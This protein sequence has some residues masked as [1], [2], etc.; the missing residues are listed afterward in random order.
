[1]SKYVIEIYGLNASTGAFSRLDSITTFKNL[2][3]FNKLNGVG[4]CRFELAVQDPKA[5]QSNLVRFKNHVVIK[6]FGGI[7]WVGPIT[8]VNGD[9]TN[10]TGNLVIDCSTVLAHFNKRFTAKLL[11]YTNTNIGTIASGLITTVL[12]RTNGLLGITVGS[13][14]GNIT[15]SRTYEYKSVS[16]ALIELSQLIGGFDF[17]FSPTVDTSNRLTGIV[18]NTYANRS[19]SV[20]SDLNPLSLGKN[21]KQI[22]FRTSQD[23]ENNSI[24]EG[25]GTGEN[26]IFST[27]DYG[28]SQLGYT[29]REVI[30]SLKDASLVETVGYYN[31]TYLN[32]ASV[33]RY[34]MD[35][36][37]YQDKEPSYGTYGL[38]DILIL[39]VNLGQTDGY[40]NFNN[41]QC[42][43]IEIAV[44][45]D[46]QA[47]EVIVPRVEVIN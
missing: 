42:R 46:S 17:D 44:T 15:R 37:L 43:V 29:R 35:L 18:F 19:G 30:L 21:I 13:S 31:Q 11:N 12:A 36:E 3:Y 16:Q 9:Y 4:G 27:L 40:V 33:E 20:R 45:V 25:A 26:V 22:A 14:T 6:R 1:M 7:V 23:I 34:L 2:S 10:V 41:K 24:A 38:G 28:A 5:T 47:A 39:N 8:S 32:Q